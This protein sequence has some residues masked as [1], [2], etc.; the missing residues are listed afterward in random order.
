MS[1]VDANVAP[2]ERSLQSFR[3]ASRWWVRKWVFL[4]TALLL[5]PSLYWVLR[6]RAVWGFDQSWYGQVSVELYDSL[7]H[8][9]GDWLKDMRG[10]FA[11]K[12]PGIAWFGQFFVPLGTRIG[13]IDLALHLSVLFCQL[14]TLVLVYKTGRTICPDRGA[15]F[16]LAGCLL[17]GAAPLFVGMSH[18]YLTEP[19]QTMAVAWVI[20]VAAASPGWPRL[21]TLAHLIAAGS[22]AMLAKA[23]SPSYCFLPGLLAAATLL[24][25]Q[26]AVRPTGGLRGLARLLF[27]LAAVVLLAG[28]AA[29]YT[30]NW[31]PA[32]ANAYQV[33]LGEFAWHYGRKEPFLK[34]MTFWL[35]TAAREGLF[36]PV[37]FD[38]TLLLTGAGLIVGLTRYRSRE[39]QP[40]PARANSL[41][42]ACL[43]HVALV[44]SMASLAIPEE[45][46]Y[47][48]PLTPS[49]AVLAVWSLAQVKRREVG[50]AYALLALAQWGVVHGTTL[51]Y[52][53]NRFSPWLWKYDGDASQAEEVE[54]VVALTSNDDRANGRYSIV[55]VDLYWFNANNFGY[56]G[57][58]YKLRSNRRAYFTSLGYA[59]SDVDKALGRMEAFDTVYFLTIDAPYTVDL[60][61]RVSVQ[62]ADR[63]AHDRHYVRHPYPSNFGVAIWERRPERVAGPELPPS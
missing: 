20:Y 4:F 45:T 18:Q 23:S 31:G 6:D 50:I 1:L 11:T 29:W 32:R 28:A 12:A 47:L 19:L 9:P 33:S 48:L 3:P 52:L 38:A 7:R 42:I 49:L 62:V 40:V 43:F 25:G 17:V 15:S 57:A 24:P 21:Q 63:V 34:K 51:G 10:A 26:R 56:Y 59:E 27:L 41:A 8:H 53:D 37:L 35:G 13:S 36:T 46:R 58:K 54:R 14:M 55:G 61:N 16:P 30:K 22:I 60:F 39:G 2:A 5:T 44:L